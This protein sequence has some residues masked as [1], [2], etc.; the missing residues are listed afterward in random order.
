MGIPIVHVWH[1]FVFL[2]FK[3]KLPTRRQNENC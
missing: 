3:I 1:G 2:G